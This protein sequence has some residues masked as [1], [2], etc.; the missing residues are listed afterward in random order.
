MSKYFK[1]LVVGK[2]DFT[3]FLFWA[4]YFKNDVL[5][6]I[7]FFIKDKSDSNLS[8][9]QSFNFT[10]SQNDTNYIFNF[11]GKDDFTYGLSLCKIYENKLK[12]FFEKNQQRISQITNYFDRF[13]F[14]KSTKGF[15][16]KS[17]FRSDRNLFNFIHYPYYDY[18]MDNK[19]NK[20]IKP[21][22]L[23]VREDGFFSH[24]RNNHF[25]DYFDKFMN[26]KDISFDYAYFDIFEKLLY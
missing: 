3:P 5:E 22:I 18:K 21:N 6:N 13:F 24:H 17:V 4:F 26:I 7:C 11:N 25:D 8:N 12:P 19:M 1:E 2:K 20:I 15:Y 14:T 23:R 10:L 16:G 9:D